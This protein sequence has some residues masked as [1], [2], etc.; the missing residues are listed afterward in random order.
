MISD[1]INELIRVR[2]Y[3]EV[4]NFFLRALPDANAVEFLENVIGC[5][6]GGPS[7]KKAKISSGNTAS[8]ATSSSDTLKT[9]SDFSSS[10]FV[11]NDAVDDSSITLALQ[12]PEDMQLMAYIIGS[13]GINVINI[14]KSS[15]TKIQLEKVGARGT[16]QHRHVFLMGPL[17]GVLKAYQVML[18]LICKFDKN[19]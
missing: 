7:H 17:K 3:A 19:G 1:D 18:T 8:A 16:D 13:K 10:K 4:G 11:L 9:N 12:F 5:L 15:G 6:N 14:G 2:N